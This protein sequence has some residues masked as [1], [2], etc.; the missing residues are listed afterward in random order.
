M[1]Q[2]KL[3]R[4]ADVDAHLQLAVAVRYHF[5]LAVVEQGLATKRWWQLGTH[6]LGE[7]HEVLVHLRCWVC[8]VLVYYEV[9]HHRLLVVACC[10]VH[11]R[12]ALFPYAALYRL[13]LLRGDEVERIVWI[14]GSHTTNL[15]NAIRF[16]IFC[17]IISN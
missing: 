4:I 15:D 16:L 3:C 13:S 11:L 6:V 7:R 10:L 9:A 17:H 12:L 2:I 8:A 5:Q 1:R 14:N